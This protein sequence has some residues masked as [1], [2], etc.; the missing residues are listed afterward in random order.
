MKY[1]TLGKTG[2]RVSVIGIGTWQLGGEWGKDFTQDEVDAM[3][4][5]ARELGLNL[6]DTAECYGDH[7]SERLIGGAI[8]RDREKWVVATKFGHRF[9]GHMKRAT[10]AR[11]K[12]AVRAARGVAQRRCGPITS[13]CSSI[14]RSPTR[15]RQRRAPADADQAEAAGQDP[16]HR[17]QHPR[18]GDDH[19]TKRSEQAQV[20][21]LQVIY[22]RLDRRPE[23]RD[24]PY[25]LEHHLGI[26]ARVPLA[27]G[28]SAASTSPARASPATI[29]A[30]ARTR[31]RSTAS[32]KEVEQ[33]AKT[34]VPPGISYADGAVGAFSVV[35]SSNP[36]RQRRDPP[37]ARE[38][39][40]S[41]AM[42]RPRKL[43]LVRDD[44]PQAVQLRSPLS[45]PI[46]RSDTQRGRRLVCA[47][48]AN[49]P[50][51]GLPESRC[52]ECWAELV[53]IPTIRHPRI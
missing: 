2:L 4:D 5:K 1:R 36:V 52:P 30:P 40:R 41:R 47:G 9:I 29:S 33:I 3:F 32:C 6:I 16:P 13:T 27:S 20:E 46:S 49:D 37:A 11:P 44:H 24:F 15:V 31:P 28:T 53:S 42:R 43:D 23:Q 7:T 12:D 35:L 25:A 39:S 51:R 50:L 18:H 48:S 38:S 22:N 26:L 14:T 34:E 21:A 45:Q 19:Q 8:A 17:Q 10:S